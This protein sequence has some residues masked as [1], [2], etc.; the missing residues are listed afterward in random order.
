MAENPISDDDEYRLEA[1]SVLPDLA[2]LDKDEVVEEE[3]LEAEEVAR[4]RAEQQ[5]VGARCILIIRDIPD[6]ATFRE[7]LQTL[8]KP[9]FFFLWPYVT[10]P[11]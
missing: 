2:R 4:T 6:R 7:M 8:S 10:S 5:K 11:T 9:G 3:R 1:L